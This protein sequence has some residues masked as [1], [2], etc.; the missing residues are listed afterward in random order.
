[1]KIQKI[2]SDGEPEDDYERGVRDEAIE[3]SEKL[4]TVTPAWERL[5]KAAK[6]IHEY[7]EAPSDEGYLG[8]AVDLYDELRQALKGVQQ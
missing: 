2:T 4:S 5:E 3:T 8:Q 1:M 7:W 6:A